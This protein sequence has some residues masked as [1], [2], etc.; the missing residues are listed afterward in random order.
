MRGAGRGARTVGSGI[1]GCAEASVDVRSAGLGTDSA[2][3]RGGGTSRRGAVGGR[4]GGTLDLRVADVSLTVTGS[5]SVSTPHA[6]SM[7]TGDDAA[8]TPLGPFM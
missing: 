8:P 3:G 5:E 4:F 7:A 1:D 2:R 6:S